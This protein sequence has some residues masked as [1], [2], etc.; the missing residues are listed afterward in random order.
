MMRQNSISLLISETESALVKDSY[1]SDFMIMNLPL[2]LGGFA[3]VMKEG[4]YNN[5]VLRQFSSAC[6]HI[7]VY[8]KRMV[9]QATFM[10]M[11]AV[12]A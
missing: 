4:T 11:M 8:L 10:F 12:A 2:A 7:I 3:Q 1:G 6:N 5:R 9:Y